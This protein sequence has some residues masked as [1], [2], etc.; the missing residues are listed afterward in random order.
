MKVGRVSFPDYMYKV[1]M[2]SSSS[3]SDG[4]AAMSLLYKLRATSDLS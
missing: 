4:S 2:A 1:T 3:S